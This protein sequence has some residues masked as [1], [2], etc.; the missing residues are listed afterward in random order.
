MVPWVGLRLVIVAFLGHTVYFPHGAMGLSVYC[1]CGTVRSFCVFSSWCHGLVC[2]WI[3][4]FLGHTVYFPHGAVGLSVYCDCR[5]SWSFCVFSSWCHGFVYVLWVW[6][7]L[8][9]LCLF[10]IVP[11][12]CLCTVIVALPGHSVFFS[13]GAIGLSVYC[14]CGNSCS[15]CVYFSWCHGFVCEL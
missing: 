1:D 5:I 10:L 3:V 13:H 11:W 12:V 7:F 2:V 9:S 15:F 4:V 6:H 8:V 14:D